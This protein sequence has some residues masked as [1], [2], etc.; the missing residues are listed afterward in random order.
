MANFFL[1]FKLFFVD[2][3][4]FI[5]LIHKILNYV[6]GYIFNFD[7]LSLNS[8]FKYKALKEN[9]LYYFYNLKT[10]KNSFFGLLFYL[11]NT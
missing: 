4:L 1:I 7:L 5:K 6:F 8:T 9:K 3:L 11:V 10:I 2:F